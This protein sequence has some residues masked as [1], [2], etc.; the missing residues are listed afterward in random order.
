MVD[1]PKSSIGTIALKPTQLRHATWSCSNGSWN[2]SGAGARSDADAGSEFGETF[3]SELGK[4]LVAPRKPGDGRADTVLFPH[5]CW[6]APSV[7]HFLPTTLL[8]SR[9]GTDF[10]TPTHAL[11][12]QT[13]SSPQVWASQCIIAKKS[14][15][16]P[17]RFPPGR[18][19]YVVEAGSTS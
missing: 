17:P 19:A 1:G 3:S 10:F 4:G 6:H 9:K 13:Y 8:W 12:R 15:I 16:T 11:S 18:G 2:G 5:D 14:A 7:G